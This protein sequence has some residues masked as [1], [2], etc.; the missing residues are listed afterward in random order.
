[1]LVLEPNIKNC[2]FG[3]Q[4]KKK[5]EEEDENEDGVALKGLTGLPGQ[6]RKS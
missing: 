6:R 2:S 1:M 5:K 4:T 3:K